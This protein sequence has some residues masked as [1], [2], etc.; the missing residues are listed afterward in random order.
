MST[1]PTG[2]NRPN[3]ALITR[4][5]RIACRQFPLIDH[6]DQAVTMPFFKLIDLLT[7]AL[8]EGGRLAAQ[9]SKARPKNEDL[10]ASLTAL[11]NFV[12]RH[13]GTNSARVIA[14][15]LCS[16][17]NGNRCKIDLT[18]L[19]LLDQ[20]NFEHVLSALRLDHSPVREVH[21]YF[22]NGSALWEQMFADYGFDQGGRSHG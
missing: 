12:R 17:Y 6:E 4:A 3:A 16:L 20:A 1:Q 19:R 22:E 8:E 10:I 2:E 21:E 5:T 14:S 7:L 11:L 13:P 18:G 9:Q 15:V